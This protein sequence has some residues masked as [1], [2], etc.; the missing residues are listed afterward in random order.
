MAGLISRPVDDGQVG[1]QPSEEAVLRAGS[2]TMKLQLAPVASMPTSPIYRASPFLFGVTNR[3]RSGILDVT[4]VSS[5]G[6]EWGGV[7][8]SETAT[9][10]FTINA[11]GSVG[12]SV[13]P[14]FGPEADDEPEAEQG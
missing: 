8:V 1:W 3:G 7:T 14:T 6:T 4:E 10:V 12:E 2:S 5:I 9:S 13:G 11:D